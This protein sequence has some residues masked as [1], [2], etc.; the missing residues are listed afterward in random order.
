M[1]TEVVS[2]EAGDTRKKPVR[3]CMCLISACEG[4]A[5]QQHQRR[6]VAYTS[7]STLR[8]GRWRVRARCA[9]LSPRCVALSVCERCSLSRHAVARCSAGRCSAGVSNQDAAPSTMTAHLQTL[10]RAKKIK[11]CA[12]NVPSHK[13]GSARIQTGPIASMRVSDCRATADRMSPQVFGLKS[14]AAFA[15]Q[16]CHPIRYTPAI[17]QR[18]MRVR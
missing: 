3:R 2:T 5:L 4:L 6:R 1:P 10:A 13:L 11:L 8:R 9:S 12:V 15:L 14:V 7:V 17:L 18:G 16:V